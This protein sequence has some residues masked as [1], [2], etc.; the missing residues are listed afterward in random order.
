MSKFRAGKSLTGDEVKP[1]D[2]FPKE[3][4]PVDEA[5]LKGLKPTEQTALIFIS[6]RY[7]EELIQFAE[8]TGHKINSGELKSIISPVLANHALREFIR[9]TETLKLIK[10]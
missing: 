7:G 5:A 9:F 1:N 8:D 2:P 3:W 10:K 6:I 4:T